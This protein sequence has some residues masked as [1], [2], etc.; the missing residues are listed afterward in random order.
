MFYPRTTSR[1]EKSPLDYMRDTSMSFHSMIINAWKLMVSIAQP[2]ACLKTNVRH[3]NALPHRDSVTVGHFMVLGGILM[4]T[5]F[6]M[7]YSLEI[8]YHLFQSSLNSDLI[9]LIGNM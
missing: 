4:Y 8:S 3:K 6:H 5:H 7:R 2:W 1:V 9:S